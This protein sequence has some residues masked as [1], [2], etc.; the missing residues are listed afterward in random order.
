MSKK[1]RAR[2]TPGRR[3]MDR[4][5]RSLIAYV[6]RIQREVEQ[7]KLAVDTVSETTQS[8]ESK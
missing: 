6:Q 3:L 7:E 2:R 4:D 5:R 1:G 8:A